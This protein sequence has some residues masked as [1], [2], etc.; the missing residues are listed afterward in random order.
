MG[1]TPSYEELLKEFEALKKELHETRKTRD[2]LQNN[3][4]HYRSFIEN[5]T[6]G[7]MLLNPERIIEDVNTRLMQ[8]SGYRRDEIIG[9]TLDA[10]YEK[11]T[12]DFYSA[13]DNHF[14]FEAMFRAKSGQM[15]PMLFNRSVLRDNQ[16]KIT[17]YMCLLTDFTEL[18]AAQAEERKAEQQ[19]RSMYEHA[20][21]GMFQ[22][23]IS[24][25][26][27][28]VNPSFARIM[29]Y[30]SSEDLLSVK[31]G[32]AKLF[33]NPEDRMKVLRAV[34]RKGS[35]TNYELRL[36]R[37]DGKPVWILANIRLVSEDT[38]NTILEG[39]MVDNTKK[40]QLEKKLKEG[41][42]K[43]RKLSVLD[44]LTGLYNTRFLY[45]RLDALILESE[46]T[47]KP[48]S[49]IFMD[50]DDFKKVVDTH[51]HLNGSQA[52]RE[53]GQTIKA[54]IVEPCFGVAYGGDEFVIVLPGFNKDEARQKADTIRNQMKQ[55]RYLTEKGLAVH[56]SASF[57]LATFPGD[58]DNRT[59]LLALADKAMFR[60]KQGGKDAVGTTD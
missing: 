31:E 27:I 40:K 28:R 58:T 42:E 36:K 24:G 33:F 54:A 7:F 47:D 17:G 16:G 8:I 2:L 12:V 39:I 48:F 32:A 3:E 45:Q 25:K 15:I 41:R 22:S 9:C 19:Y 59:G 5:A 23:E 26:F 6:E 20:L 53:V 55:T 35:V 38:E 37:K 50:L 52:I 49:L 60:V 30:T 57:G 13:S 34:E 21:Q 56:L 43:F 51:G 18:R 11:T 44:N 29:G 1:S 4:M 10:F 14:N 46:S